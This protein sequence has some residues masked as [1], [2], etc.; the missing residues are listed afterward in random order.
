KATRLQPRETIVSHWGFWHERYPQSL[1]FTMF[2]KY[3]PVELP[4]SV[5]EDSL[6]SR[7]P[8]DRRLPAD[9]MV[10]GIWDGKQARAYPLDA[11][12]KAGVLY[13]TMNDQARVVFWYGPTRTA[14]AYRPAV[15]VNGRAPGYQGDGIFTIDPKGGPA[16][17]VD[18][19]TGGHWDITGR[20]AGGGP[21]L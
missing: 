1:A 10:L 16:P 6:K 13:E 4:T 7:G 17:F 5:N 15:F 2:E 9:T 19:R 3:Q 11:L 21:M 20:G 18:K 12:E 8:A 14:A